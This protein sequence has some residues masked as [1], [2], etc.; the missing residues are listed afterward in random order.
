MQ[1]DGRGYHQLLADIELEETLRRRPLD[2][3]AVGRIPHLGIEHNEGGVLGNEGR[4]GATVG[5]AGGDW[6]VKGRQRLRWRSRQR[7]ARL[8]IGQRGSELDGGAEAAQFLVGARRFLGCQRT[9]MP[10]VAVFEERDPFAFDCPRHDYGRAIASDCGLVGRCDRRIVVAID[11]EW[12][13]AEGACPLGVGRK[14]PSQRRLARLA[15][16]VDIDDRDEVAQLQ[17]SCGIERFPD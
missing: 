13:P 8:R 7:V 2:Q 11:Y 10:A 15:E 4:Q 14:V 6:L 17:A 9:T 12:S 16:P 3:L 5:L 1:A